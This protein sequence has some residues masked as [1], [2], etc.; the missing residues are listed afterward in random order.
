MKCEFCQKTWHVPSQGDA[1]I[2]NSITFCSHH[3]AEDYEEEMHPP[4]V[5][6]DEGEAL[7]PNCGDEG[8]AY[9]D[10][11]TTS[12]L[13]PPVGMSTTPMI[14]PTMGDTHPLTSNPVWMMTSTTQ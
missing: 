9:C 3:C 1:V 12:S 7:C 5:V 6:L 13:T 11:G 14:P 8:C 10:Q 4:T 2:V